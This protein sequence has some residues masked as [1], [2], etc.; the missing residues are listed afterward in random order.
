MAGTV[1]SAV[2]GVYSPGPFE[3][4]DRGFR[5]RCVHFSFARTFG[6]LFGIAVCTLLVHSN[7]W[8]AVSNR[9]VYSLGSLELLDR[10]FESRC[11]HSWSART[12]G[13]LFRIA[14]C[15]FLVRT[16]IWIPVSNRG[17]YILGS[18][19]LLDRCFESRCVH[20]WFARSFGSLFRIEVCTFFVR[21]NFWIAVSNRG[22]YILGTLELL[23]RCLDTRWVNYWYAR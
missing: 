17:V 4:W 12:F 13:S 1:T 18:L 7:F 16:N 11:V 19:E 6:S 2:G 3:L 8:I 5:S 23:Y 22:G 21:S 10:C 14:V 20:S 15:T 9:D